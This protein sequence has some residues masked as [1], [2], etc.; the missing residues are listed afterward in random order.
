M[1]Q[2][3]LDRFYDLLAVLEQQCGGKRRLADCDGRS[4]WPQRGIYFF[5][6]NGETRADGVSERVTRVGTHALGPSKSTLWGRLSQHR[7]TIGGTMPGGGNHRGSIFRRHVGTALLAS[8]DWSDEIRKTWAIGNNAPTAVRQA[9]YPLEKAVTQYIGLM[10]F[11]W[12]EIDDP[13][14][15]QS[16]RGVIEIGAISLLSNYQRP[17]IDAPSATWLGKRAKSESIR[18]SG[19]W[20]VN[21]VKDASSNSFIDTLEQRIH[22]SVTG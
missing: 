5:F 7:G 11:L 21:H 19:I 6:E 10:P 1:R 12:L 15:T 22:L 14:S 20:N 17:T 4:N 8:S 2:D 16:D 18:E 3:D 13:P 9:E